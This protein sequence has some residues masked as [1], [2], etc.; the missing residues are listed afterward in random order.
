MDKHERET[1]GPDPKNW[2]YKYEIG[3]LVMVLNLRRI[4]CQLLYETYLD[5]YRI[6]NEEENSSDSL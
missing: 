4:Y 1:I 3:S 6:H 2:W 5:T